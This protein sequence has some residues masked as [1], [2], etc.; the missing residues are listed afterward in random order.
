MMMMKL[1]K[2]DEQ[3]YFI[4]FPCLCVTFAGI[5]Y[6]ASSTKPKLFLFHIFFIMR[7]IKF[8]KGTENLIEFDEGK[9]YTLFLFN[10]YEQ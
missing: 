8:N 10:I 3:K 1:K 9:R 7:C 4:L 6:N 2:V 5:S